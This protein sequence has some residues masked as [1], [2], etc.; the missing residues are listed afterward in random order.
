MK[1][2]TIHSFCQDILK[3]FPLEAGISPY[4]EVLDDRNAKEI[5]QN[6]KLDLLKTIDDS[7]NQELSKAVIYLTQTI[8]EYRFPEIMNMITADRG[9]IGALLKKYN[10]DVS[11]I[12]ATL[13]QKFDVSASL[14]AENLKKEFLA[15]LDVQ[16]INFMAKA[17]S[18][19]SKTDC[20][21]SDILKSV[22][23]NL[24][25]ADAYDNY[26]S[27]FLTAEGNIRAKLATKDAIKQTANISEIMFDAAQSVLELENKLASL[28]FFD[29]ACGS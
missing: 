28:K 2:Q 1:I 19:G 21:R 26:K 6:I 16:K 29:P 3:R 27:V 17:L 15:Q 14:S 24:S 20:A 4:F 9:K 22:I 5:L 18:F 12:I 7:Q 10:D 13:E 23:T 11:L 25:S 8:S